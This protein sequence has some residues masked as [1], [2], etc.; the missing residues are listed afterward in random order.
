M[1]ILAVIVLAV[2]AAVCAAFLN[3]GP[4]DK[5]FKRREAHWDKYDKK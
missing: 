4:I 1:V 3:N 5:E 2:F